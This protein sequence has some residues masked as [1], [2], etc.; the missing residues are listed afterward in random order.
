MV[1]WDENEKSIE[2]PMV[3]LEWYAQRMLCASD[4]WQYQSN[5]IIRQSEFDWQMQQS[6][7]L[8]VDSTNWLTWELGD[9]H[10]YLVLLLEL[11]Q[12]NMIYP[13]TGGPGMFQVTAGSDNDFVN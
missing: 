9:T 12:W 4:I 5:I 13:I 2:E 11:S 7:I 1:K 8:C 6:A 3:G 10:S